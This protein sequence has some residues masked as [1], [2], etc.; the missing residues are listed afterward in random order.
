MALSLSLDPMISVNGIR[1]SSVDSPF[2]R[3]LFSISSWL[4]CRIIPIHS[5]HRSLVLGSE[6]SRN[7]DTASGWM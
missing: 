5:T 1:I 4:I 6:L 7:Q 2:K 3:A